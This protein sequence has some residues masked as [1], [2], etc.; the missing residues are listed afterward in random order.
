M[1][2]VYLYVVVVVDNMDYFERLG[3][4]MGDAVVVYVLPIV[5]I[6]Y[7]SKCLFYQL[8]MPYHNG[9]HIIGHQDRTKVL[10]IN[11]YLLFNQLFI[12]NSLI[13]LNSNSEKNEIEIIYKNM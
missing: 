2:F 1:L 11:Y 8:Y 10:L 3:V 5:L 7:Y 6:C 12:T 13:H 9:Q 4:F